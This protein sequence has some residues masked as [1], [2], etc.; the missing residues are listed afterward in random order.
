MAA[1]T[2]SNKPTKRK[3]RYPIPPDLPPL[4]EDM[5]RE[6]RKRKEYS[7]VMLILYLNKV[8]FAAT[9]H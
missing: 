8:E 3:A 7:F 2:A 9:C 5:A 6:V 4:L 1:A